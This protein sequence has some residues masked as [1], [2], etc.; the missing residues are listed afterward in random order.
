MENIPYVFDEQLQK[1]EIKPRNQKKYNKDVTIYY[2]K[3][4]RNR[5]TDELIADPAKLANTRYGRRSGLLMKVFQYN[6]VTGD[7]C[8]IEFEHAKLKTVSKYS[9][10]L[11]HMIK[12]K[13]L[14]LHETSNSST[15][16]V[17]FLIVEQPSEP[18]IQSPDENHS[19]ESVSGTEHDAT[20]NGDTGETPNSQETAVGTSQTTNNMILDEYGYYRPQPF[21]YDETLRKFNIKTKSKN[22]KNST[23]EKT[24]ANGSKTRCRAEGRITDPKKLNNARCGRSRGLL[25]S[26]YQY[27]LMTGDSCYIEFEHEETKVVSKYSSSIEYMIKVQNRFSNNINTTFG[28]MVES[29]VNYDAGSQVVTKQSIH[30][31]T[32]R[33]AEVQDVQRYVGESETSRATD[34]IEISPTIIVEEFQDSS[35]SQSQ[36]EPSLEGLANV[37]I[38][39]EQANQRSNDELQSE[40]PIATQTSP[41]AALPFVYDDQMRK[42]EVKSSINEA[43]CRAEG[44]IKDPKKLIDARNKNRQDLLAKIHEYSLLTGDDCYVQFQHAQQKTVSRYTSTKEYMSKLKHANSIPAF[45][46]DGGI[47]IEIPN[48]EILETLDI[49]ISKRQQQTVVSIGEKLSNDPSANANKAG[50]VAPMNKRTIKNA[51]KPKPSPAKKAKTSKK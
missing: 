39:L 24:I 40:T 36:E 35:T 23:K 3:Q 47:N 44:R 28:T 38:L 15:E 7:H 26:I 6:L 51:T 16:P 17:Q 9:S 8:Y 37:T 25:T 43:R 20:T 2:G 11:E 33:K 49:K 13:N 18:S 14:H 1:V 29:L 42:I 21:L 31:S 5:T 46:N 19:S 34:S 4:T 50:H 32:V 27:S 22:I 10:S 12:M 41:N 48:G 45:E 30:R